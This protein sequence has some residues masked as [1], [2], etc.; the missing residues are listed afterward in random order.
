M[1][2]ADINSLPSSLVLL[3]LSFLNAKETSACFRLNT[4]LHL[5]LEELR[6]GSPEVAVSSTGAGFESLPVKQLF[7]RALSKLAFKPHAAFVFAKGGRNTEKEWMAAA[8]QSLPPSTHIVAATSL[9]LHY[10]NL[11]KNE[12]GEPVVWGGQTNQRRQ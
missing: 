9:L 4:R 2:M 5:L 8:R 7:E 11:P 1:N 6:R 12:R 3:C 10:P